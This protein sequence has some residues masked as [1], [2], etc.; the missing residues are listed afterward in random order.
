M[1]KSTGLLGNKSNKQLPMVA[2]LFACSVG[3]DKTTLAKDET[4]FTVFDAE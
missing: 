1:N 4:L 2:D 3:R